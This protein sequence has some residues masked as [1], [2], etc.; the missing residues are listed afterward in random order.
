MVCERVLAVTGVE[1][2][3]REDDA[4]GRVKGRAGGDGRVV[5]RGEGFE[6]TAVRPADVGDGFR[7]EFGFDTGFA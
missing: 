1:V 6:E 5:G 7:V 2:E 3:P 4:D